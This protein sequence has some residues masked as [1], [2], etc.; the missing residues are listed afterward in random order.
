ML[1]GAA[2]SVH[3]FYFPGPQILWDLDTTFQNNQMIKWVKPATLDKDFQAND[4]HFY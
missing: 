4:F 3:W 2:R 1:S